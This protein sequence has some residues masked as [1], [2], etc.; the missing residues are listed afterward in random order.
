MDS[1]PVIRAAKLHKPFNVFH[2]H[3]IDRKI[4]DAAAAA[5]KSLEVDISITPEGVI[6]VGHPLSYYE[7]AHL[8]PP[9]NLPLEVVVKEARAANLFLVLDLKDT[10]V[11]PAARKV[12]DDYG[13]QDCLVHAF[14]KELSFLPWPPK[15]KAIEE[16][17][18][19][20]EEL[21]IKDLL[22][23]HE[24][25]G[26]PLALS[27]RGITQERLYSEG[28]KIIKRI[29][30]IAERGVSAISLSMP[31]DEDVPLVFA[32]KLIG[33]AI[34]PMIRLDDTAPQNKPDVCLGFTD[35]LEQA[36]DPKT[37]LLA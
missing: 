20:G 17:N 14:C 15:V 9:D 21:P 11:I 29:V 22:D 7:G 23:L 35:Y 6:Y 28:E 24:S 18:W 32:N 5:K 13:A 30:E 1:N 25:T 36:T 19:K 4:M 27:C 8:P 16:P 37:A 31:P 12:I 26:V 2:T 10:K 3:V 34:V 33:H